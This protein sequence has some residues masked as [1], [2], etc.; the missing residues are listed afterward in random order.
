MFL[1]LLYT[2]TD[3]HLVKCFCWWMIKPAHTVQESLIDS[4]KKLVFRE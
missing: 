2:L 1:R 3:R 4:D